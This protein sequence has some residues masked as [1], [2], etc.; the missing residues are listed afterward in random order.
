MAR[1]KLAVQHFVACAKMEPT[2]IGLNDPYILF[3][4]SY[5]Y[6]VV[7]DREWPAKLD[8]LWLFVRF[9]NGIRTRSFEVDVVWLDGPNGTVDVCT[10]PDFEV[11]FAIDV[12]VASR[13]FHVA[14]VR[15]PGPGRYM[16]C[17]RRSG[18]RRVLAREYI[19]IRRQP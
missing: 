8:E 14:R 6:G 3:G 11:H 12:P 13:A 1:S 19:E 5:A 10:I 7:A 4:V 18:R 9:F 16:F 15:Y 17:L 2:A